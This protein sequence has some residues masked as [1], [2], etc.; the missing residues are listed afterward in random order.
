M[1][2]ELMELSKPELV[3]RIK[4]EQR[5]TQLWRTATAK[6][7]KERNELIKLVNALIEDY[8]TEAEAE[9]MAELEA[10]VS[11]ELFGMIGRW[12]RT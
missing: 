3:T 12:R 9:I 7:K 1:S 5:K 6:K 11:R 4:D 8:G 10:F 2:K